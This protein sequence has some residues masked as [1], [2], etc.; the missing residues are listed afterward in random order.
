MSCTGRMALCFISGKWG[1]KLR[2]PHTKD[3]KSTD[4][5]EIRSTLRGMK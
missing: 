3:I 4:Y 1:G 2:L 5:T